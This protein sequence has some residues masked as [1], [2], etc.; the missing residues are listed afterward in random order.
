MSKFSGVAYWTVRAAD[1]TWT[2]RAAEVL[3]PIHE[4]GLAVVSNDYDGQGD[5]LRV[6][7]ED[8]LQILKVKNGE[9]QGVVRESVSAKRW[10]VCLMAIRRKLGG[11]SVVNDGQ[12]V[13]SSFR[14]NDPFFGSELVQV[15][16]IAQAL[17]L[18]ASAAMVQKLGKRPVLF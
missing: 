4:A 12:E 16:P 15:L 18:A 14:Q 5:W 3:Q 6:S 10:V 2:A 7:F 8:S 17:G 1:A 11:L 13:I 9:G